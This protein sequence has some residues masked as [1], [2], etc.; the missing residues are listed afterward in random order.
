[1][2]AFAD[3]DEAGLLLGQALADL[4]PAPGPGAL[5]LGIPRGGVIVAAA[6]ARVIGADLDVMVPAKVRAPHQPE[7]A[8]GAVGP[9]GGVWLDGVAVAALAIP[10]EVLEAQVSAAWQ[11]V[12]RR[13]AA[14]RGDRPSPSVTGR[15]VILVDDGIATGATIAAAARALRAQAP[16]RLVVAVPV[17]PGQAVRHLATEVDQVV[18][19]AS[20]E[21]FL[22]VGQWYQDFRQVGDEAVRQA[23]SATGSQP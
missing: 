1:M 11:E 23:L 21:P 9:D 8:I 3:R 7:L 6:V 22:A 5:V 16:A 4:D 14:F 15:F 19:L 20:P 18:C 10:E 13:T 2:K 12:R 17:A